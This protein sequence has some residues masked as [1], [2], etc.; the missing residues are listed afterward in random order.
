MLLVLNLRVI[1]RVEKFTEH[2]LTYANVRHR[3]LGAY[4]FV[5]DAQEAVEKTVLRVVK[6]GG[7][8][9]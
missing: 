4:A 3:R 2:G 5:C 8:D 6:K 7:R 9:E 1:G